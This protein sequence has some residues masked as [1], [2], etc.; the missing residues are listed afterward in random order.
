MGGGGGA[1]GA[2]MR[3]NTSL[4]VLTP[5]A[6][7]TLTRTVQALTGGIEYLFKKYG[8]EYVKGMGKITGVGQVSATLNGG[9]SK[10]LSAKNV[11]IATGSEPTPLPPVPVDNAKGRI[12]DSTGALDL[13]TIPKRLA[14]IGGGVIGLEMGSVWRRLGT[15]VVVIEYLD[16]ILPS[17][18]IE[19]GSSF[20]K[21]L[22]KQGMKFSLS[23]KV[24]KSE[25]TATG[26]KLTTEPS[27][28]GAPTVHDFDVVLVATGRRP[29]T[30]GLGLPELGVKQDKL[31]RVI[32][33]SSFK[34]NVSVRKLRHSSVF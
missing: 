7:F 12:V 31:G 15:E 21:I 22:S 5:H 11:L 32:V 25:V 19:T 27:A 1:G 4:S 16:K 10:V 18:D 2:T 13:K 28:G 33:D 30:A 3:P 29:V 17:M 14:V 6:P 26:V 20:Q 9:G 23:T 8:V 24:T 34:T